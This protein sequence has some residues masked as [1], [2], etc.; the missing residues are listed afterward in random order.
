MEAEVFESNSEDQTTEL[1]RNFAERLHRGDTV[2][3][4]GDLGAG[5][6]E[7][8]KGVCEHFN[9][10]EIVSSPTF[11]IINQYEG[12]T[13]HDSEVKIYHV[14]LYRINSKK[15]LGDIGFNEC[16][17][18]NDAIKLIEWAEKAN[19]ALPGDRYSVTIKLN[20]DDENKRLIEIRHGGGMP[21]D[22]GAEH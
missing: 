18:S 11:S 9:V 13:I 7:F 14:D 2:A 5:K 12:A 21:D 3:I 8:V 20:D 16:T 22:E 17:H 15:E 1:G 10:V 6:T 19:G 4:Y